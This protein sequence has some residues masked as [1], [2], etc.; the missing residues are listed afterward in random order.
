MRRATHSQTERDLDWGVIGDDRLDS[1]GVKDVV[2]HVKGMLPELI[3]KYN[4]PPDF[5]S[6]VVINPEKFNTFDI[7]DATE[8]EEILQEEFL[9][10][11]SLYLHPSFPAEIN[12]RNRELIFQ[13]FRSLA[14]K[15]NEQWLTMVSKIIQ[16]W[17]QIHMLREKHFTIATREK[18]TELLQKVV[19]SSARM[20][21]EP[22]AQRL[23]QTETPDDLP[24]DS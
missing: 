7:A 20:M 16:Y 14:T 11:I 5:H 2:M 3:K 10:E 18:D 12:E 1:E 13:G 6:C 21:V 19:S 15:D 9:N 4:L 23:I 8:A 24:K 22:L 17:Q